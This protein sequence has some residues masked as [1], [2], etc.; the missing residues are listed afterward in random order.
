MRPGKEPRQDRADAVLWVDQDRM[1]RP[2]IRGG[3]RAWLA[4]VADEP[5]ILLRQG[6]GLRP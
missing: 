4:D 6:Y 5:L 2:D 3:K 1:A